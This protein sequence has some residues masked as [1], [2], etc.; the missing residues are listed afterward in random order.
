M[1]AAQVTSWW[2]IR[3]A[4]V[5]VN[6][7]R[8]YGAS[9]LPCDTSDRPVFQRLAAL[10]PADALWLTSHLMRTSQT[11][12][13][14]AAEM[15]PRPAGEPLVEPRIAEQCFG[16]WQGQP[17]AEL[18]R[19]RDGAWH[20][21]WLAPARHRPPGGESFVEVTERVSAA[22]SEITASHAG[23]D[24]VAVAHGGTIRAAL[25]QALGLEPERAL[26]FV[27]DNCALTRID[28]ID[29]GPGSHEPQGRESW[30]VSLVNL[31][32]ATAG[33]ALPVA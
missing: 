15:A 28:H 11:A 10:M 27:I 17:Y 31:N 26:S 29:G 9:D 21:F 6:E 24:I 20:R 7:G 1:S 5:R 30:R 25:G 2:W 12:A 22:V 18:D 4:P 16:D 13:A 33:T 8:L 14:I 19:L 3:H 23:R 32:P